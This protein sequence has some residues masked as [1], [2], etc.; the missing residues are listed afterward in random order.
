MPKHNKNETL[1]KEY[2]EARQMTPNNVGYDYLMK[3][4]SDIDVRI[5]HKYRSKGVKVDITPSQETLAD[6]FTLLTYNGIHYHMSSKKYLK[7]ARPHSALKSG[8][9]G[10]S[11]EVDQKTFIENATTDLYEVTNKIKHDHGTLE[12]FMS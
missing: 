5:E 11:K 6:V 7:L 2:P 1:H 10:K 8:W 12:D 3:N 4:T 9:R